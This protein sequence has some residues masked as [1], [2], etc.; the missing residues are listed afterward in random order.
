MTRVQTLQVK[1]TLLEEARNI[2]EDKANDITRRKQAGLTR[3]LAPYFKEFK[4]EVIIDVKS[5]GVYFTMP[6]PDYSYN[7]ELFNIY[8]DE[9][10]NEKQEAYTGLSLSYYT[11][12]TKGMN[13][14]EL[15]RLRMLGEVAEIIL[16]SQKEILEKINAVANSLVSERDEIYSQMSE[17]RKETIV[18]ESQ[19]REIEKEELVKRLEGE[20]VSFTRGT[21]LQMKFNYTPNITSIKLVDRSK[22]GKKAKAVFTF[23][24]GHISHEENVDVQKITAQVFGLRDRI[25]QH[26]LA[27]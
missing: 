15:M 4:E 27:E 12:Q 10:W 9:S 23:S 20:G 5:G 13:S 7:K 26:T 2:L 6:H 11:T 25:V 14:W 8:L 17:L 22:S 24:H 1:K 18:I 19:I 21:N 3:V 16:Y